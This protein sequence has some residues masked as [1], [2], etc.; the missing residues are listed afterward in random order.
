MANERDNSDSVSIKTE[1][2]RLLDS[3][4]LSAR[5]GLGQNFLID[6]GVLDKIVRAAGIETADT[7]VEV[8][9]GPGVMTAALAEKA[10]QVIAVELDFGMVAALRETVGQRS[11]VKVIAGDILDISP[12][13]LTGASPY[14]VVANLPYY[15]TSPVLRHFLEASHRPSSLT[16]MVQKEVARQITA[17]PP[18]M[19][20]LALGV[21]FF[22]RP[23]VVSYVPAGCFYPAPKVASAIL[24]IEVFPE[25]KLP[26]KQEKGFFRLARAGFGTRR[27]Q[28]ANALSGGLGADKANV[29]QYLKQA[30]IVPERRAETLSIDEWLALREVWSFDDD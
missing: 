24:H 17:Q 20:L 18:E 3:H 10:G 5:K 29:I 9:P 23:R 19:S 26:P 8:G 6:R 27:K 22:G 11:N 25:R 21:Q 13:E 4:G 12:S 14:K 28:L 16:V 30:G 15:I 1:V 2:R 7:V